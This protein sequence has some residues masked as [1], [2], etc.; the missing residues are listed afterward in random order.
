MKNTFKLQIALLKKSKTYSN[1]TA[2]E[3][4]QILGGNSLEGLSTFNDGGS[5]NKTSTI[6]HK[7]GH[8]NLV[9]DSAV[10]HLNGDKVI[11]QLDIISGGNVVAEEYATN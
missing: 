11:H 5:L 7:I 2:I 9:I 8:S 3:Q 6:L 4:K 10:A 1:L